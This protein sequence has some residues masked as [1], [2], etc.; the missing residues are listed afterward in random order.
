MKR[1]FIIALLLA[2]PAAPADA[3]HDVITRTSDRAVG[4]TVHRLVAVLG[5]KGLTV[6]ARIDHADGAR[7]AGLTL[8]PSV[9]VVFGNPKAGTVLM[10]CNPAAGLDLPL[11]ILVYQGPDGGSSVSYSHPDFLADRYGLD[12]CR[13]ILD[14]MALLLKGVVAETVR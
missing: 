5:Q 7:K 9:V 13:D 3:F 4:E 11:K 14:K 12:D 2:L 1:I 6:F 8:P 10:K